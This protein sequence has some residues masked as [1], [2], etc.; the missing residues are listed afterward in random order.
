M[1]LP[2][3]L[4]EDRFYQWAT[5]RAEARADH[6]RGFLRIAGSTGCRPCD[7]ARA[8]GVSRKTLLRTLAVM[9]VEWRGRSG[10]RRVWM[11]VQ[12]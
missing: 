4:P 7:L 11:E 6:L 1:T 9:P 5:A 12:S 3:M 2:A 10:D 8:A